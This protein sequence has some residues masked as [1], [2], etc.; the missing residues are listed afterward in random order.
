LRLLDYGEKVAFGAFSGHWLR[1][2]PL[3]GPGKKARFLPAI[4]CG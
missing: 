4:K 1:F 2:R 3:R